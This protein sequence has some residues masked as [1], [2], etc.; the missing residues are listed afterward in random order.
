M[1]QLL[2]L[3][4]AWTSSALAVIQ[5]DDINRHPIEEFLDYAW[6]IL[7]TQYY[8]AKNGVREVVSRLASRIPHVHL[9]SS[10]SSLESDP[11]D[12]TL[13]SA[14]CSNAGGDQ[15]FSG[16][17]H[18]IFATR[19]SRAIPILKSYAASLHPSANGYHTQLVNDQ[20]A[21]LQQF[22]YRQSIVI[23]RTDDSFL[24]DNAKDR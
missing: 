22:K 4:A 14:R 8:V 5:S 10:I 18:V 2:G 9:S 7:G 3:D 17:N 21:C 16:F 24:P 11:R 15:L 19:A 1:A 6:L 23:N 13:V 20:I 12:P